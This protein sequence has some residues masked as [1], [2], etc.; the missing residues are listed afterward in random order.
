MKYRYYMSKTT[1]MIVRAKGDNLYALLFISRKEGKQWRL[2][3]CSYSMF[4]TR[5]A[6]KWTE[7]AYE[8]VI[9]EQI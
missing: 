8:D 9:L 6:H 3:S 2:Q 5:Y 7:I 1:N 4:K